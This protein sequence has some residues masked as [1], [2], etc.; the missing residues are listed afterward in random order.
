MGILK[1]LKL[2][3][4]KA[5]FVVPDY[6]NHL[7]LSLRNVKNVEGVL[8]ADINTYDIVNAD[9]LLLSESAA[10]LFAEQEIEPV[11]EA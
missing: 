11:T 2:H 9:F 10:K 8:M 7:H 6:D 1:E 4:K 3:D 5:L